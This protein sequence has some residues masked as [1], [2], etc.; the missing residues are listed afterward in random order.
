MRVKAADSPSQ[1]ALKLSPVPLLPGM[2]KHF[3]VIWNDWEK[4]SKALMVLETLESFLFLLVLNNSAGNLMRKGLFL[5]KFSH[6]W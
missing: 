1:K 4:M 6:P 5:P 3:E 2:N